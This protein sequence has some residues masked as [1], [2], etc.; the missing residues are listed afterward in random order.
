M[1][2]GSKAVAGL[3]R[4]AQVR[5]KLPPVPHPLVTAGS[6]FVLSLFDRLWRP[7]MSQEEAFD[8]MK[9]GAQ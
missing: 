1:R 3:H 2:K 4:A 5:R 7:D 6:Y 9:K 8:L